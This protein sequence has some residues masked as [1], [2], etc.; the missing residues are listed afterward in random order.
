MFRM[1]SSAMSSKM[2]RLTMLPCAKRCRQSK[3]AETVCDRC[4]GLREG[5]CRMLPR[6]HCCM[7][8]A[9]ALLVGAMKKPSTCL[10]T[11]LPWVKLGRQEGSGGLEA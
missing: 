10:T 11:M 2:V 6:V 8:A 3:A 4:A 5:G 1:I 7:Q 9:L